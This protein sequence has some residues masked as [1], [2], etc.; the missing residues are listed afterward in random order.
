[1]S[2]HDSNNIPRRS[3]PKQV[4]ELPKGYRSTRRGSKGSKS[5]KRAVKFG[6]FAR[7]WD[8]FAGLARNVGF[9]LA[10]AV[11]TLLML[12]SAFAG[13]ETI[14]RA[15]AHAIAER[16]RFFSYGDAMFLEKRLPE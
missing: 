11:G 13:T 12:V 10:M 3:K 15:Y 1:M 2:D 4:A 9:V 16:Y 14:R 5:A 6:F 7:G 8:R